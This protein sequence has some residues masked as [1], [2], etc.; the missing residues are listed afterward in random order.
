MNF[1]EVCNAFPFFFQKVTMSQDLCSELLSAVAKHKRPE[2]LPVLFCLG[3]R[4]DYLMRAAANII[5]QT[6]TTIFI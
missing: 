5:Q 2:Y 3:E 1:R 6:A 4:L